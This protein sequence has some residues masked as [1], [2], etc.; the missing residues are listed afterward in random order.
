M[1]SQVKEIKSFLNLALKLMTDIKVKEKSFIFGGSIGVLNNRI[2]GKTTFEILLKSWDN[3]EF[4]ELNQQLIN[5]IETSQTLTG[6]FTE[7]ALALNKVGPYAWTTIKIKDL[8]NT[9][10]L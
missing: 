3:K 8:D 2:K 10:H 9:T 5:Q 7:T 4:P 6:L 1:Q